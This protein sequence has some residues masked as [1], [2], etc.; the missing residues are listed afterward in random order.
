MIYDVCNVTV[1]VCRRVEQKCCSYFIW[2]FWKSLVC[3]IKWR[4]I[5][6][7]ADRI[8]TDGMFYRCCFL[9]RCSRGLDI[10]WNC[11]V[12]AYCGIFLTRC[13]RGLDILCNCCV[14]A[15]YGISLTRW[16]RGF[17]VLCDCCVPDCYGTICSISGDRDIDMGTQMKNY[18]D[19]VIEVLLTNV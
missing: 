7:A 10:L 1:C 16:G 14:P 17:D 3:N 5:I 6:E 13:S 2:R 18:N 9:T 4:I 12:P 15:Y 11:C 19:T 8:V